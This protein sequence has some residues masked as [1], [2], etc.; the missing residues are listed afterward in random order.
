MDQREMEKQIWK[1][2][3]TMARNLYDFDR[4]EF[5]RLRHGHEHDTWDR[6]DSRPLSTETHQKRFDRALGRVIAIIAGKV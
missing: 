4:D 2:L 1:S 3:L 6:F 5:E